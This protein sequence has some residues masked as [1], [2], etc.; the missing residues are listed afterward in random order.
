[1]VLDQVVVILDE[2]AARSVGGDHVVRN[3]VEAAQKLDPIRPGA[4]RLETGRIGANE[5]A[6]ND[7][8]AAVADHVDARSRRPDDVPGWRATRACGTANLCRGRAIHP[9][10][11][12]GGPEGLGAGDVGVDEVALNAISGGAADLDAIPAD[13][14]VAGGSIGPADQVAARKLKANTGSNGEGVGPRRISADEVA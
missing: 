9:D 8:A 7:S 11:G 2:D 1:V 6:L 12:P 4:K 3:H 14:H 10:P 5:I 13:D